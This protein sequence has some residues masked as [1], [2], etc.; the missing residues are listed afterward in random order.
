MHIPSKCFTNHKCFIVQNECPEP[1]PGCD[2]DAVEE[3]KEI[4]KTI[5]QQTGQVVTVQ[6]DQLAA[7]GMNDIYYTINRHTEDRQPEDRQTDG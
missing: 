6:M 1:E 4:W 5:S 3:A 7:F 2:I